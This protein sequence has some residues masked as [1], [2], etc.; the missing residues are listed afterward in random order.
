MTYE[1]PLRGCWPVPLASYLKALGVLR[2]VA[3]QKDPHAKGY[4]K[5]EQFVLVS[6]LD[7]A[8]LIDFFLS[9]YKPTPI[10][11]PWG[12][13][14]GFYPGSSEK[15]A[16]EAL[17]AIV[18]ASEAGNAQIQ[19]FADVIRWTRQ[20]L[21]KHGLSEKPKDDG[22]LGLLRLCRASFP[23]HL[24]SWLD[25]C[26]VLTAD[27]RRFPPLLGTGGNEGSGSYASGFAQQVVSC[28]VKR[29]HDAVLASALFGDLQPSTG[30][31]QTPGQFWPAAAG[32]PNMSSGFSGPVT[33]NPW[34]YLL[35]LEGALVF[36]SAATRRLEAEATGYYAFPFTVNST[37]A[38][39][40]SL[41]LAEEGKAR[42]ELWLPL[43]PRASSWPELAALF[44][45]GRVTVGRRAVRDGLDFSRA[46]AMLGVDLGVT[47]FQR[48]I[49]VQ[50]L[51][52]NNLAIPLQRVYVQRIPD[53]DLIA[54]LDR[55][56]F[57]DRLRDFARN[58]DAPGSVRHLTRR[59][60]DAL[61]AL[62]QRSDRLLLQSIL[63]LLG[64]VERAVAI[65]AK[66]RDALP[67]VP[68]LR[69]DWAFRADDASHEYRLAAA[70]AG[71]TALG[72]G[73]ADG[74]PTSLHMRAHL[75]PIDPTG[76]SW[77]ASSRVAVWGARD[78]VTNLVAVLERRALEAE[79]LNLN[80]K[81]FYGWPPTD[82]AAVAAFL[83]ATTDDRRI[84]ELIGGLALVRLPIALP[85]R[86]VE[87]SPVPAGYAVFKPFFVPDDLLRERRLLAG[88][89]PLVLPRRL[90][91]LL[92]AQRIPEA[93]QLAWHRL[94][95]AG[96]G[97]P[98]SP[99]RPP[100]PGYE[101]GRRLAAALL[102]PVRMTEVVRHC[103]RVGICRAEGQAEIVS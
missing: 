63:I 86:L 8:A 34:D 72:E 77:D 99:P 13:R 100:A 7:S 15:T 10:V 95:L 30:S 38:G 42:A 78:L 31:D 40:G 53:V 54:D 93:M 49:V 9:E 83:E 61:F 92:A 17:D 80:D 44:S 1:L 24:V 102:V 60:E 96:F 21:L 82:T 16:R 43:W 74:R 51:G 35:L 25:A 11:A 98:A 87:A 4:W 12:A 94:R 56:A 6:V 66:A 62:T 23:E 50:R 71:L 90:L 55:L 14:S 59:L 81:P 39:A 88:D 79:R 75:A 20:F 97:L 103:L 22:K 32:G 27:D 91:A 70:L 101:D 29:T 69:P 26:Y 28:F 52:Q 19:P 67:P 41:S 58:S 36:S 89:R 45:Q 64:A 5:G 68:I 3:E 85:D 37:S 73:P 2:L 46:I 47:A 84:A 76:H 18:D 65:S 57:L 48:H 33:T